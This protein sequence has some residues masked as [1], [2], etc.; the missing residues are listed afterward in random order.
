MSRQRFFFSSQSASARLRF[1]AAAAARASSS[2]TGLSGFSVFS[3]V[4]SAITVI[5]SDGAVSRGRRAES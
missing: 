5:L 2:S 1:T 4:S 3:G